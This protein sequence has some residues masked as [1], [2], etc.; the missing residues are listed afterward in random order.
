[1]WQLGDPIELQE[2]FV[3]FAAKFD[4]IDGPR[5]VAEARISQDDISALCKWF[6]ALYGKPRNWCQRDWQE[7]LI[8]GRTASSREMFGTLFLILASE[9][10]RESST[11]DSVW[12]TVAGVMKADRLSFSTLF[13]AGQPTEACKSAMVAGARRLRLRNLID[14]HGTQEY[15]DTL[16]LQFGFTFKGAKKRLVDW[17]DGLPCP[18]AVDI[19]R[20]ADP[21]Y[22]D[23]GSVTFQE[24]WGALLDC[25]RKRIAESRAVEILRLSPWVRPSW[26][27]ELLGVL[28]STPLRNTSPS[29]RSVNQQMDG[30]CEPLL[31]WQYPSKPR[32]FLRLNDEKVRDILAGS[33]CAVFSVDGRIVG[34]WTA[35]SQDQWSGT[36]L[37]PSEPDSLKGRPNLRPKL[38]FITTDE[39]KPLAE[40]DL[41]DLGTD[42][43]LLLF[44]ATTGEGIGP[45]S[46]L[47]KDRDYVML[48]DTDLLVSESH[49]FISLPQCTVHFLRAPISPDLKVTSEGAI[50]WQPKTVDRMS[51]P[52]VSISLIPSDGSIVEIGSTA[53]LDI[54]GVPAEAQSVQL[55]LGGVTY[56]TNRSHEKPNVWLTQNP[57]L[58]TLRTALG[59]ERIRVKFMRG[60]H[61]RSIAPRLRLQLQGI[62]GLDTNSSSGDSEYSWRLLDRKR[63]RRWNGDPRLRN[64]GAFA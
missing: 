50:Y 38:L 11:E 31:R 53:L 16:K 41:Q 7:E 5:S 44:D 46:L 2:V 42:E 13:A 39:G 28:A 49:R 55:V 4:L 34:R 60:D 36:R 59:E 1:L 51:Q 62:A 56:E 3:Y 52:P 17:L 15:F 23:L 18:I 12:P 6:S 30:I 10:C 19:L 35:H 61:A 45:E 54:D 47:E 29:V 8:D 58:I 25:R 9:L 57:V 26:I 33:D 27:L 63:P 48:C 20:S 22:Q 40:V 24:T 32:L 14:R 21:E 37:L 43:P 64:H